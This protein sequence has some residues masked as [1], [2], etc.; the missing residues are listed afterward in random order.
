VDSPWPPSKGDGALKPN[1][2]PDPHT[3][4]PRRY[5][6]STLFYYTTILLFYYSTI[7]LNYYITIILFYYSDRRYKTGTVTVEISNQ[8]T[9]N[10]TPP[11]IPIKNY[12][13]AL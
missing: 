13:A 11:G 3:N 10:G 7:L 5:K 6:T 12:G 1:P 2:N 8:A 9:D 4:A